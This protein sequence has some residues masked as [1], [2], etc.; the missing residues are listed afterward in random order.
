MKDESWQYITP[1]AVVGTI[2]ESGVRRGKWFW[3]ARVMAD[4]R[5]EAAGGP[6]VGY[7]LTLDGA[8]R[9]VEVLCEETGTTD[10]WS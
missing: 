9:I 6:I 1:L 8:K 7:A 2:E 5:K 4:C 3:S 10:E